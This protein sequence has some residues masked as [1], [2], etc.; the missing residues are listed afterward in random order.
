MID[1]KYPEPTVGGIILND[2]GEVLILKSPKWKTYVIPGGHVEVNET[3]EEALK[4]E[5]KEEI[6]IDVEVIK[7]IN[8][9]DAIRPKEFNFEKHFIFIDFLCRAKGTNVKVD[10]KEITDFM[11]V[12][13]EKAIEMVDTHTK[14]DLK[15]IMNGGKE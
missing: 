14:K 7:K 8:I 9:Q 11:W 10:K 5:I 6:G 15:I 12:K 4:R 3:M 1:Q 13:P 2:K